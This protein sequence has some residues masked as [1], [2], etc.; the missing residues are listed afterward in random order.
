M[1]F[2]AE[3]ENLALPLLFELMLASA[4]RLI[5][6]RAE[7][8]GGTVRVAV[9]VADAKVLKIPLIEEVDD[10]SKAELLLLF[11]AVFTLTGQLIGLRAEN[12]EDVARVADAE[13]FRAMLIALPALVLRSGFPSD[14]SPDVVFA[15][16]VALEGGRAT[17]AA[18]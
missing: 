12:T 2:D 6:L 3:E 11:E 16:T 1:L 15:A 10:V 14:L 9:V 13:V 18:A 8:A 17:V 4:R 7:D 5:R